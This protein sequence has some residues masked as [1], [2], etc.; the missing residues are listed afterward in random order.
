[1]PLRN[2]SLTHSRR[3]LGLHVL[4]MTSHGRLS[5][6]LSLNFRA[7]VNHLHTVSYGIAVYRVTARIV[8]DNFSIS[9]ISNL[10]FS[11]HSHRRTSSV[12]PSCRSVADSIPVAPLTII[13][14]LRTASVKLTSRPH[15]ATATSTHFVVVITTALLAS[16]SCR[17]SAC[18]RHRRL[19]KLCRLASEMS[20]RYGK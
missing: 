17:R 5:S 19:S 13:S 15:V 4:L 12:V 14:D 9:R 16:L 8:S 10:W 6:W 7:H 11:R 3:G 2:Y 18:R 20:Q 1:M